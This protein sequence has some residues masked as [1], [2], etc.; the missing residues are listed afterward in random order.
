MEFHASW[1]RLW[2]R[3]DTLP[4]GDTMKKTLLSIALVALACSFIACDTE[5]PVLVPGTLTVNWTH[6]AVPTCGARE[7]ETLR[8]WISHPSDEELSTSQE[9]AC[10]TNDTNGSVIFEDVMPATYQVGIDG[11]HL[12]G[13]IYY[14]GTGEVAVADGAD[15]QSPSIQLDKRRSTLHVEYEGWIFPCHKAKDAGLDNINVTIQEPDEDYPMA[16]A[17][18]AC[19]ASFP[20]PTPDEPGYGMLFTDLDPVDV[21]IVVRA[22]DGPEPAE[23]DTIGSVESATDADG[24]IIELLNGNIPIKLD[25]GQHH[26]VVVTLVQ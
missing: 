5:D 25:P 24:N 23:A 4:H 18:G 10:P 7:I 17:S 13:Q 16:S 15:A 9:V 6:G 14:Q 21:V 1:I 22:L 2:N 20:D 8:V 3:S 26:K 19:D 11:I 12:D